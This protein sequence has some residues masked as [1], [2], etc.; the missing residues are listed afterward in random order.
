M[1]GDGDSSSENSDHRKI[2]FTTDSGKAEEAEISHQPMQR[3]KQRKGQQPQVNW[4]G[5]TSLIGKSLQQKVAEKG[6][7]EVPKEE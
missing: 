2:S 7:N 3:I 6:S 1:N 5:V 4:R